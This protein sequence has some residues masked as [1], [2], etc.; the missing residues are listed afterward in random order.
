MANGKLVM[1]TVDLGTRTHDRE[2]AAQAIGVPV[3]AIDADHGVVIIDPATYRYVVLVEA[4][5]FRDR[6]MTEYTVAGPFSNPSI[7]TFEPVA[8]ARSVRSE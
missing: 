1:V 3:C 4:V 2:F 8:A 6:R 5:A 7:A